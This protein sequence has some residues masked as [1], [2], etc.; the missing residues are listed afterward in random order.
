MKDL[1]IAAAV[2][3]VA[4]LGIAVATVGIVTRHGEVDGFWWRVRFLPIALAVCVLIVVG[5]A[6]A[7]VTIVERAGDDG[8]ADVG[9]KT[10]PQ[11]PRPIGSSTPTTDLT[12]APPDSTAARSSTISDDFADGIIDPDKWLNPSD[13]DVVY[14]SNGLLNFRI[15]SEQ[16]LAADGMSARIEGISG[17]GQVE[18]V[19]Y[20][21]TLV[22][23]EAI[24][25]EQASGV[26][27]DLFM[28][29]GRLLSVDIGANDEGPGSEFLDCPTALS[30]Y[31]ECK[32][33]QGPIVRGKRPSVVL[34]TWSEEGV[35]V[36]FN[37]NLAHLFPTG[38]V[39]IVKLQFFVYADPGR[40]LHLTVDDFAATYRD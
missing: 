27:L 6:A 9:E 19:T 32:T 33:N 7:A 29:D 16:S 8:Q 36:R 39:A 20:K 21:A 28:S 15:R 37:G 13:G 18:D 35:E 40:G 22:S 25:S 1:W 4:V 26:R 5:I 17:G 30:E 11:T 3:F 12:P 38:G 2:T 14:E 10:M 23:S 24:D 31:D 34:A